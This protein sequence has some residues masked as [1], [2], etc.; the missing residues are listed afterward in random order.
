LLV[1]GLATAI[2]PLLPWVSFLGI[3][4]NAFTLGDLA[5]GLDADGGSVAV[6]RVIAV[7]L[8]IGGLVCALLGLTA[9]SATTPRRGVGVAAVVV[10]LVLALLCVLLLIGGMAGIAAFGFWLTLFAV[11][12]CLVGAFGVA[13]SRA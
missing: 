7:G 6:W 2:G 5:D 3:N 9:R 12:G 13:T 1:A 8:L 4:A 11:I 10:A